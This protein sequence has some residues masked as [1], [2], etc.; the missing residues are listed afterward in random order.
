MPPLVIVAAVARNGVI[1]GDN[2]LIWRLKSDIKHFRSLTLGMPVIM[3]RKT[4]DSIGKPLPGRQTIVVSRE[5]M[6]RIE[7]VHVAH[8]MDHALSMAG[9]A[10]VHMGVGE[11]MVAGGGGDLPC[12][13]AAGGAPRNHRSGA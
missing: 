7:G 9:I 1:G 10:A 5:R 3:G 11:V 13:D 6:L 4:Y 2:R 12:L 8:S